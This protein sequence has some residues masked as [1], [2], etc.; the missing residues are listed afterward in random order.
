MKNLFLYQPRT[1]DDVSPRPRGISNMKHTCLW[2]TASYCTFT[3][4]EPSR[5]IR[6]LVRY[7]C[8]RSFPGCWG[9]K[10]RG[11]GRLDQE[12]A[13]LP[14]LSATKCLVAYF[15]LA[16]C[17][18]LHKCHQMRMRLSEAVH[19]GQGTVCMYTHSTCMHVPRRLIGRGSA[20]AGGAQLLLAAGGGQSYLGNCTVRVRWHDALSGRIMYRTTVSGHALCG[21]N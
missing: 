11:H 21:T 12:V 19:V 10:L 4:V 16:N 9:R 6:G 14:S 18:V 7:L 2:L 15:A 20:W 8:P 5:P 13:V 1:V 3:D 17:T